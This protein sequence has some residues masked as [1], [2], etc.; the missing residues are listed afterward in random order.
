[1]VVID[2]IKKFK[3]YRY[4]E[5]QISSELRDLK[6]YKLESA[7]RKVSPF[8]FFIHMIIIIDVYR[9]LKIVQLLLFIYKHRLND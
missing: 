2:L 7:L 8:L 4:E 1:M 6:D 5:G 9:C 3:I